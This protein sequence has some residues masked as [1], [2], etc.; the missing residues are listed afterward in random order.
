MAVDNQQATGVLLQMLPASQTEDPTK[1]WPEV[2]QQLQSLPSDLLLKQDTELLL[3]PFQDWGDIQLFPEREIAFHCPCS[4]AR[5]EDAIKLMG[6][7]DIDEILE[8]KQVVE[9][10]CEYCNHRYDFARSD[11]KR[12]FTKTLEF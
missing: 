9:V 7:A 11:V 12:I 10:V 8:D 6:K 2:Q 1:D 5:M 4:I 3:T